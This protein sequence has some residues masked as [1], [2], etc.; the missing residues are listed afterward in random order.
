MVL[1][2]AH[3]TSAAAGC[4]L[5]NVRAICLLGQAKLSPLFYEETIA[6]IHHTLHSCGG[7]VLTKADQ[8]KKRQK[9][10]QP[11]FDTTKAFDLLQSKLQ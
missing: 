11:R 2:W 3:W 5:G 7:S 1:P 9:T 4:R 10:W 8:Q 6:I